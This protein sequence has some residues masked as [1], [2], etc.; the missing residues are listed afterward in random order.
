MPP[1]PPVIHL[2]CFSGLLL[3][4]LHALPC[5]R[6]WREQDGATPPHVCCFFPFSFILFFF[7][8]NFC[9]VC[10]CVCFALLFSRFCALGLPYLFLFF[11]LWIAGQQRRLARP[12]GP[13]RSHTWRAIPFAPTHFTYT[14]H[15][16]AASAGVAVDVAASFACKKC[17]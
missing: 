12:S 1:P 15:A 11:L 5:P 14:C 2:L 16:V 17:S 13:S 6:L 7:L 10:V 4:R 8:L 9:V 3:S